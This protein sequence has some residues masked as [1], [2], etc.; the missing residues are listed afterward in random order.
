MVLAADAL[1][2]GTVVVEEVSEAGSVPDLSVTN[3]SDHRVLFLEGEQ[4]VGAK[5]NRIL[6]TSLLVAANSKTT[7]P[8][9]CVEQGRWRFKSASLGMSGSYSLSKLRYAL[10]AS[11]CDSLKRGAGH[12]S[13]QGRVWKEVAESQKEHGVV[14]GTSAME[15]IFETYRSKLTELQKQFGYVSGASGVA[16]ALGKKLV[17]VDLF[18]KPATCERVWER[19]LSG[20]LLD[21]LVA[22]PTVEQPNVKD[23][24]TFLG[25]LTAASWE[26]VKAAAEGE[27]VRATTEDGVHASALYLTGNL[28]H[29]S[30]AVGV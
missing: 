9:S 11:V 29:G 18:D 16:V 10:K 4:L 20:V 2:E 19:M 3:K 8:V 5:Q 28:V 6:N 1:G 22:S 26:S 25:D 17:S 23:A 14:S 13:D 15:D 21:S 7:I 12:R 24:E 27:E 30:A